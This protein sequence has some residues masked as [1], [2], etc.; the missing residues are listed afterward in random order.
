MILANVNVGSGPNIGDGD[1][2]RNAFVITNNNSTI[3][4]AN[5][6]EL[7]A[8]IAN[9]TV[10]LNNTITAQSNL[11]TNANVANVSAN[12][13]AITNNYVTTNTNQTI[14]AVK[15]Y[16]ST[17]LTP[18]AGTT[19]VT[20]N[21]ANF[22]VTLAAGANSFIASNISAGVIQRGIIEVVHSGSGVSSV[23]FSADYVFDG[24]VAIT[25]PTL[26]GRWVI[27]YTTLSNNK[28]LLKTSAN[29]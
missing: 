27:E 5:V 18:A 9:V 8:N 7:Y 26:A 29:I 11:S 4:Q 24:G 20:F 1:L 23:S 28:V 21:Y 3:V 2:L 19:T 13:T 22:N 25:V 17:A 6:T 16:I 14:T 12:V 10:I 15:R